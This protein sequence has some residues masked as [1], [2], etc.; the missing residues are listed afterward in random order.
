MGLVGPAIG[1]LGGSTLLNIHT[2]FVTVDAR[3]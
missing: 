1:Y 2:D 3:R